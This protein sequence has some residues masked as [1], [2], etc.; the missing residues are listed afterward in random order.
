MENE[1][2]TM[3]AQEK[4]DV[5]LAVMKLMRSMRRRP[6]RPEDG[7]LPGGGRLLCILAE[8]EGVSSRELAELLDIRPSS[9]SELLGR[10]EG[11][12]LITRAADEADK[13]VSRVT[14]TEK[15]RE[16]GRKAAERH[17]E[18]RAR[19]CACFTE[20][21]AVQFCEMCARLGEHMETLAREEGAPCGCPEDMPP[22]PLPMPGYR[23]GPFGG[24]AFGGFRH[25]PP[26]PRKLGH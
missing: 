24:G 11:E 16:L 25:R 9:L 10:L 20:E 26:K 5:M 17:E 12:G 6:P 7:M 4:P 21:E 22:F 2:K 1:N 23:G 14:L 19:M 8:N 18:H 15:G 13:R 3:N